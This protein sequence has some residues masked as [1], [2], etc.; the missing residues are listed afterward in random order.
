MNVFC[1][2]EP[3]IDNVSLKANGGK[4]VHVPVKGGDG[5]AV[6]GTIGTGVFILK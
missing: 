6:L 4:G 5:S 3:K 1:V 2:Q